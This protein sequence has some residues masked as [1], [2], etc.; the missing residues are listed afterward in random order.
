MLKSGTGGKEA[1]NIGRLAL[2]LHFSGHQQEDGRCHALAFG[3]CILLC[4]P[5]SLH[6]SVSGL[7]R[8]LFTHPLLCNTDIHD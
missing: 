5:L 3:S 2:R 7:R 4:M 1:Q 6:I 8:C